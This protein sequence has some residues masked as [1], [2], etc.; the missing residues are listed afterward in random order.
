MSHVTLNLP[1]LRLTCRDE[2]E[3]LTTQLSRALAKFAGGHGHVAVS[4]AASVSCSRT[5][6]PD[7]ARAIADAANVQFQF[8]QGLEQGDTARYATADGSVAAINLETGQLRL[9][10]SAAVFDAPYSTWSDLV[11]APLAAAWRH[12][13]FYPLHAAAVSFDDGCAP[14]VIGASGAGKTT[15]SLALLQRGATWRSDDKV[16]L[17]AATTTIVAA[18]L[19][20]NTN[21]APATI[22]AHGSL[23]FAMARPPINDTNDKRPCLLTHPVTVF[24]LA[25][26]SDVERTIR[27]SLIGS[28]VSVG[29]GSSERDSTSAS[30]NA[31][32]ACR[33]ATCRR[34]SGRSRDRRH[35]A[36]ARAPTGDDSLVPSTCS[37]VS[38]LGSIA[39]DPAATAG[40][41]ARLRPV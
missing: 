18:S 24:R 2:P 21:L 38:V 9:S 8:V 5:G 20:A 1:W 19:Y 11:A 14:L 35:P 41:S 7:E 36:T 34:T 22:A 37:S 26:S 33:R 3:T 23:A 16:L 31:S 10:L 15:M 25:A 39:G 30:R 4:L 27:C 17:H 12:H 13:G 28:S 40:R 6:H 29:V 32:V